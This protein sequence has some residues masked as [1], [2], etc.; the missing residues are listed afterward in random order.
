MAVGGREAEQFRLGI[1]DAVLI[2]FA[3]VAES[4]GWA[5]TAL[6]D[7]DVER[8]NQ[9][10]A[11]DQEVDERC[12]RLSASVKERLSAT[13]LS[14][15]ELEYLVAVLQVIPE[16]ERSADLAE[17]IA[18]RTINHVGGLIT[19]RSRGLIQAM[20]DIAVDMWKVAGTAYRQRSRDVG[21]RLSD[22]DNELD[23]LATSLVNE[24][25]AEGTEPQVAVDLAHIAPYYERLGDHAV[26]LA[27]RVDTMAAPRRLAAPVA[28]D[29]R[30]DDVPAVPAAK[31]RGL[32]RFL[33]PIGNFRLAP[34]DDGF[35]DLFRSA[36]H[37]ARECAIAVNKLVTSADL[38]EEHIEEVRGFERTGDELTVDLLRRLDA[39]FV[40]PFDRE[41]IH[42]L[43]E[44]LDD[45]VDDMFAAASLLQ[46]S[47]GEQRPPELEE[48]AEVLVTMP[49]EMVALL[50]CLQTKKG[51]R[52]RLERIE[53]LERQG[54]A[55]FQRGLARLFSGQYEA[56][57]VIK[58]KDTVQSLESAINAIED[59]S[60]V[61][62]SILVKES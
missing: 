15:D 13:N 25:V 31:R 32:H 54:D 7:Q 43:A 2:L 12:E 57:E 34:T 3:L 41:D 17:H 37:N 51:A 26:N 35:F 45:V 14:P 24:G 30:R 5:T 56:L 4:V 18:Q 10:I 52:Y 58:W 40:T 21:F 16:L 36:A 44:E 42:A 48:L 27:R 20:S 29:R 60:D 1:D 53:H 49:E 50:D 46:L 8:A 22:A 33:H 38:I 59:V 9:V 11:D 47:G 61:V 39:S 6:L 23:D 55:I 19:P 28:L 62:E